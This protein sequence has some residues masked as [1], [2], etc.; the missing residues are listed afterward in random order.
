MCDAVGE[1][2]EYRQLLGI[3]PFFFL[4]GGSSFLPFSFLPPPPLHI[5]CVAIVIRITYSFLLPF[6]FCYLHFY[7][8]YFFICLF[9]IYSSAVLIV[10]SSI[11][12]NPVFLLAL[13]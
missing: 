7:Y 10:S 8:Y 3:D 6:H 12:C 1:E 2:N 13:A 9:D 11:F 5:F 4:G